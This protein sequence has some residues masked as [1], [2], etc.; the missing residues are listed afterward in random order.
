MKLIYLA[1]PYG[2]KPENYAKSMILAA[3]LEE[4]SPDVHVFNAVRYFSQFAEIF[5]EEE[6]MT[7][8]LDMVGRCD[9]VWVAAGWQDSPGCKEEVMEANRQGL[10]IRYLSDWKEGLP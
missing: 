3:H 10:A 1:H 2:G 8:C 7:R 9:Q 6:I 4:K 5:S